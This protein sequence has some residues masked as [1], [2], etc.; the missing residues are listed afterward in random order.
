MMA[1]KATFFND[2]HILKLIMQE[3]SPREQKK[4]GRLVQGFDKK[5]WDAVAK[6]FVYKGNLAKFTQNIS[7]KN[8]LFY[9]QGTTLVEA[10]PYDS[11]WGIGLSKNDLRCKSRKTWLGTNWL[12]ETLTKV[13]E[14][15]IWLSGSV[16]TRL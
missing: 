1:S 14:D 13:R 2:K 15:L 11:I 5:K 12:G 3:K 6:D 9:T 7:L 8:M 4:L 10:N 16:M